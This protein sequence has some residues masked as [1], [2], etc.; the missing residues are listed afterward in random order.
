MKK[1]I[2][3]ELNWLGDILFS[4]PFIKTLKDK[5]PG[6]FIA[7]TVVPRYIDLFE[8]NPW[9]DKVYT[10]SESKSFMSKIEMI[11]LLS[12]IKKE[13]YDTCF[14][15][16]PS[17]SR[18]LLANLAGIPERIGFTGKDTALTKM[19]SPAR[20]PLHRVDQIL[21][22]L[23]A[24][25]LEAKENRYEYF[26]NDEHIRR[27]K[28]LLLE[29]GGKGRALVLLNPGGNGDAK[30]WPEQNFIELA[31]KILKK[32]EE[33]EIGITGAVKD[34]ELAHRIVNQVGDKKCYSLAG[35]TELD[36]LAGIFRISTLLVS[37]DSGPLH[38]AS[39]VGANTVGLFGPTSPQVT[40]PRG[41]GRNTV[42][43][44]EAD[45]EVPCYKEKCE[46]DF[47][48]MKAITVDEVYAAAAEILNNKG[49]R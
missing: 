48:C 31:K 39:A 20:K 35:M 19:V 47:K 24:V 30:R 25:G 43:Y 22:L 17:R 8:N 28:K 37:A 40:G 26:V 38:L 3:F 34:K 10:L 9:V 1:I 5:I 15:L 2:I 11:S 7:C 49:K 29:A 12:K 14:V 23:E 33:L 13:N 42:I 6:A 16:K 18:T 21:G 27:A 32:R 4:F 41:K 46:K 44:H 45:C 36:I